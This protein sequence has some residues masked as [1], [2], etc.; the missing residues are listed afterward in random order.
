M[1]TPDAFRQANSLNLA[2]KSKSFVAGVRD[3]RLI[4]QRTAKYCAMQWISWSRTFRRWNSF[5]LF[6]KN[7]LIYA[8]KQQIHRSIRLLWCIFWFVNLPNE[9]Q[10][11]KKIQRCVDIEK[12]RLFCNRSKEFLDLDNFWRHILNQGRT[13]ERHVFDS[14]GIWQLVLLCYWVSDNRQCTNN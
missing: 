8:C 2:N 11:H 13:I 14:E 9:I 5:F 4:C 1:S 6:Q 7:K 10:L 3:N 12:Y